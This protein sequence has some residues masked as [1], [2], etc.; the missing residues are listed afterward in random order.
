VVDAS[1]QTTEQKL[2]GGDA[3]ADRV[4]AVSGYA[5]EAL[6]GIALEELGE[7]AMTGRGAAA[8]SVARCYTLAC[9]MTAGDARSRAVA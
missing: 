1:A 8:G 4:V 7:A 6:E 2:R 3:S 5:T 9:L